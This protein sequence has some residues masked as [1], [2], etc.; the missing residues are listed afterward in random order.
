MGV[1]LQ[2]VGN[3]VGVWSEDAGRAG[4]GGGGFQVGVGLLD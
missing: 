2:E 1:S 4:R 3:V